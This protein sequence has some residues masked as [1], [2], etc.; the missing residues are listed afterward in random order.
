MVKGN[1][2]LSLIF[3]LEYMSSPKKYKM[4]LLIYSLI[5]KSKI[6]KYRESQVMRKRKRLSPSNYP[7]LK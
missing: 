3:P 7:I 2:L 5:C 6:D 1:F 4:P